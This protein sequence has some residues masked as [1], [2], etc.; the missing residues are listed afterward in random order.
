MPRKVFAS[1]TRL[2]ASDVNTFLMDQTVQ[3]FAGTAARGS[4]ITEPVEGMLTYLEDTNAFEYWNS[5]DWDALG[6][7]G[8]QVF[9]DSTARGSAIP[10]P[11]A[12]L[13]TY[14]N[15]IDSL[16]VYNGT[17][18]TTDRTIQVFA[19]TAARG[20][21]IGTAV[22]GMYTHIND[23]D[24]LEFYDGSAWVAAGGGGGGFSLISTTSFTT[25]SAVSLP[26]DSFTATYEHYKLV[27]E[28]TA[29]TGGS[30]LQYRLRASGS[31]NSA[32]E[33]QNANLNT[34]TDGNSASLS[35]SSQTAGSTLYNSSTINSLDLTLFSPAIERFT[36]LV[37]TGFS[38]DST[39]NFYGSWRIGSRHTVASAF[40]SITFYPSSGTIS[41][42]IYLYGLG[43]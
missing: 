22:E 38:Q 12:G 15:D 41:G 16:S 30:V 9:A 3:T 28:I 6:S 14:L 37:G 31:D 36:A 8:I 40:D 7:Q 29:A 19:G 32:A 34:K 10:S 4:A 2:D 43:I 23:T 18:F 24:S 25:S 27:I 17:A 42:K 20:S 35:G 26:N 11:T 13:V 5:D 21:A 1:F 33:Y 39:S